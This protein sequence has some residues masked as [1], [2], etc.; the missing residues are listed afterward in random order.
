MFVFITEILPEQIATY[1]ASVLMPEYLQ[2]L[3]LEPIVFDLRALNSDG[4]QPLLLHYSA[5]GR[6]EDFELRPEEHLLPLL[7]TTLWGLRCEEI[8]QIPDA[9]LWTW[10]AD[11]MTVCFRPRRTERG[12]VGPACGV[13][14]GF[15]SVSR[16]RI[17]LSFSLFQRYFAE[18]Y[19]QIGLEMPEEATVGWD[20]GVGGV[21]CLGKPVSAQFLLSDAAAVRDILQFSRLDKTLEHVCRW[22]RVPWEALTQ[23]EIE[24]TSDGVYLPLETTGEE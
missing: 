20:A 21:A 2:N 17:F 1:M 4:T 12:K 14:E 7:E 3:Q 19:Q 10:N 8:T 11:A 16:R 13:D 9:V 5:H 6:Y 24:V 23:R 18:Q 15:V 22:V